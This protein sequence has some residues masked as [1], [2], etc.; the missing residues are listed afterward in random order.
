[1]GRA[2]DWL[3]Q[4]TGVKS[5]L[6]FALEKPVLGGASF[7]Y[8]AGSVL[9]FLLLMQLTTGIFLAMTYSASA[10]D[11]WASV[12]YIQDQVTLGWFV[13]GLHA[14]GASA[15]LIVCGLHMMQTALYGAYKKPRE[16]NWIIG[17]VM[18]GL[19]LAFALTGYLLP[20]DQTGYWAT[21]VATGIAGTTPV[22]GEGVQ[23]AAQG[24]NA[25]GNLTLTRFFG[26][27]ALVLPAAMVTLLVVH[28]ALFRRHGLT[29]PWW[30]QQAELER[31]A[32]PF[33]PH[34]MFRDVVAMA[35]VFAVL[36]GVNLYTGGATLDAPADPS[37]GFDARPEWYFRPLFQALKY[38][39]GPLETV[40]ALGAPAL[41]GL[42]LVAL[43]FM[44]R[45]A[46]RQPRA[47]WKQLGALGVIGL[48]MGVLLVVSWRE[49]AA[50]A[51][52]QDRVARA[53]LRAKRA[54]TL[55]VEN[56]VPVEGGVAVFGTE[57]FH[58]ARRVWREACAG[59]HAGAKRSA[60][61]IGPGYNSRAWI[62]DFLRAPDAKRFFGLTKISGM[63]PVALAADDVDALVE[64]VYAESGAPDVDAAQVL[65]GRSL[66]SGAGECDTCHELDGETGGSAPNLGG[67]GTVDMLS[68]F[69]ARPDHPL[70]FGEAS[71]MPPFFDELD[72]ETRRELAAWLIAL[73]DR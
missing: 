36:I 55:A 2:S 15:L 37:S 26:L 3:E 51:G 54:R 25:Y 13:R 72:R 20:W 29:P 49:D 18:M 8:V 24:G 73:R 57:R 42:F 16:V 52:Y 21:K 69:I 53:A 28:V 48:A 33:W 43:P 32:R 70:W 14:H 45:G 47:R 64:L 9:A 19:L 38:F 35:V 50:D 44:D 63:P 10:T 61:E 60:P 11:A 59:C 39:G 40:V 65:R 4:R 1:V 7:A 27:H 17:V 66:W 56:G 30:K 23:A 68:T 12:A 71:E 62:R 67:R 5:V 22:I 6:R 31:R 46:D 58:R 34:Q 41:L